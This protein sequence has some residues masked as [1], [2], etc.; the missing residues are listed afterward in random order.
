MTSD[1]A[2]GTG[3]NGNHERRACSLDALFFICY[4]DD[5]D[6]GDADDDLSALL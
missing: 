6:D 5:D 2:S 3:L 1:F 4:D